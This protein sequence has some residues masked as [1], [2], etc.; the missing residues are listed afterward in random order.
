MSTLR[1]RLLIS[2][3][4]TL[5]VAGAIACEKADYCAK[6][7]PLHRDGKCS[8]AKQGGCVAASDAECQ[9]ARSARRA[10]S[11][12]Q[13]RRVRRGH[14]EDCKR[15]KLCTEGGLCSA[16]EGACID[17]KKDFQV[18]C[19]KSC[20]VN[21]QCV[22]QK[23][24]CV[25]L[26]KYHCNGTGSDTPDPESPCQKSGLCTIQGDKCLA[27][28]A[29]DCAKSAVCK[30]G[31]QCAAE[32][33]KCVATAEQCV[34]SELCTKQGQCTVVDGACTAASNATAR[35]PSRAAVR[36]V[37]GQGGKCIAATDADCRGSVQCQK[38]KWCK[39]I[40]GACS[41]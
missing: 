26:S 33:G 16:L 21:G 38:L 34:K 28:S 27:A 15:S 12:R 36:A 20:K 11:A 29:E 3:T 2:A 40:D 22:Q 4:A 18:A 7:I 39:A 5:L 25:A 19:A 1:A 10:A 24:K 37:H 13:E 35:S 30:H 9:R 8:G 14:D 31:L 17:L 41:K 32:G 6:E 23:G